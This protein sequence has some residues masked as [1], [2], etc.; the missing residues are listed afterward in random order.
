[1]YTLM[2]VYV[3]ILIHVNARSHAYS[4]TYAQLYYVRIIL[5][6]GGEPPEECAFLIRVTPSGITRATP[7]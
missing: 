3:H 6:K 2:H 7:S 4:Y 1:M 5:F